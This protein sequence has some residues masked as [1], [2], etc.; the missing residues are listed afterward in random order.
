MKII[1]ETFLDILSSVP[2]T[3]ALAVAILLISFVAGII[4]AL[5]KIKNVPILLQI[6]KVFIAIFRGTPL[7]VQLFIFY[8]TLPDM[9]QSFLELFGIV[10][11]KNNLNAIAI[12]IISFSCYYA[13]YQQETVQ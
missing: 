3:I 6:V 8:Y 11:D 7:L 4:L 1:I 13:A 5:I 12:I 9:I 2:E 10:W